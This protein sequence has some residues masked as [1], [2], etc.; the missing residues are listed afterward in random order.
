MS[1]CCGGRASDFLPADHRSGPT[2]GRSGWLRGKKSTRSNLPQVR[3]LARVVHNPADSA[4]PMR[5]SHRSLVAMT[6]FLEL[7]QPFGRSEA[8]AAG[9]TARR[10]EGA[11]GTE[12]LTRLAQGLYAVRSPWRQLP[13]WV[14]YRRLAEA[15]VRLTPDAIVSHLSG[16]VLL[17][18]PSPAYEPTKVTMTLL[19][20]TRTSRE[21]GWRQFHRGATPFEHVVIR[22]GRPYLVAART[23]IDCARDLHPRDALAV[24]DAALRRGLCSD[25]EL[26][27]MRRHQARW[28]GV[29]GADRVLPISSSLRESWLESVSA[30]ALHSH[31]LDV[32]VPQV[33][34]VDP[35]GR[36]LGRVDALWPELGVVGEAD[37]RGKYELGP[38]G[39]PD[40]DVIAAI[41]RSL[42]AQRVREDR[43]RDAG[44]EVFRWDAPEALAM[45]PVVDRFLAARERAD[46][47]RVRAWFRCGCCR[48]QLTDCPRTT[49]RWATSA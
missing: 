25:R 7:P 43:F 9:V 3:L 34:V 6:D 22:G 1:C 29:R 30:W 4:W 11:L 35:S 23:V 8:L 19:D 37:G 49:L 21:D 14:R 26:V 44:L 31:G 2:S 45:T 13:P 16:A 33:T 47:A 27:A 40:P 38:D 24:M 10:I 39:H 46:P 5:P 41:R 15:A 18:L 17:D 32:G 28:P 42:H 36:A 48:R 20:D 12:R